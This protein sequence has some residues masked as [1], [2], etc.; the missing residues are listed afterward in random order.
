MV[1]ITT[2]Q[3]QINLDFRPVRMLTM[4]LLSTSYTATLQKGGKWYR[5]VV[6]AAEVAQGRGGEQ[7]VT[8]HNRGRQE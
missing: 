2:D 7:L 3:S 8:P 1:W 6:E 4:W 5:G